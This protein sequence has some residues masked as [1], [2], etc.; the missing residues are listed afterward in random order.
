MAGAAMAGSPAPTELP[1]GGQLVS[2]QATISQPGAAQLQIHQTTAQATLN[3][4][5]FNIG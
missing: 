4:Q 2:G 1:A 3:W 5:T